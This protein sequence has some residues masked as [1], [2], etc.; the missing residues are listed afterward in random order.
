[1]SIENLRQF[2]NFIKASL[3]KFS[4]K[5]GG[6]TLLDIAVGRGGDLFKW[7]HSN[8]K[9]I[10]GFDTHKE[11]IDEAKRRLNTQLKQRKKCPYIKYFT[12]DMLDQTVLQ[13][14][15]ILENNIK[16]LESHTY[17]VV[18]CQ[19]AFHYF[20]KQMDQV[21]QFISIKLNNGG[22]F[23]GTATDGDRL[24]DLLK[25]TNVSTNLLKIN[26]LNEE[27]YIFNITSDSTNTYFDVKGES[28]E[29]FLFKEELIQTAKL[30]NLHLLET[31][32]FDEWYRMYDR[33]MTDEECQVSF[34][35]FSFS[36]IK[37]ST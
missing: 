20:S 33:V 4:I 21:L 8:F 1:M 17:D 16:G 32:S 27:K 35:N 7:Q 30:Y 29:F 13:K 31:K 22:I 14:L 11:S 26:K 5:N 28:E 10:V 3:I 9:V 23:I 19:F 2:H 36:F 34:L 24:Y 12:L 25:T 6:T 18:S 15:N 37:I